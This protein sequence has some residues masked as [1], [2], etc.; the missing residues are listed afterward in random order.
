MVLYHRPHNEGIFTQSFSHPFFK[1]VRT[2]SAY[3]AVTL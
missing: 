2:I 3:F 1:Y